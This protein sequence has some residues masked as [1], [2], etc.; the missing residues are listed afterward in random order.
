M[1]KLPYSVK[2][3]LEWTVEMRDYYKELKKDF[4]APPVMLF[5]DFD[6]HFIVEND[7]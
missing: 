3:E 6:G 1:P 2:N 7:A 5:T 4:T